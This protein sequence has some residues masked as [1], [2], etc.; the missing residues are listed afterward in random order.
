[1]P[2]IRCYRT[3]SPEL[4]VWIAGE[5]VFNCGYANDGFGFWAGLQTVAFADDTNPMTNHP[6]TASSD[7]TQKFSE[8]SQMK[9]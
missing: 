9:C 4:D 8:S 1:M 5:E 3:I 7:S 2:D 6:P